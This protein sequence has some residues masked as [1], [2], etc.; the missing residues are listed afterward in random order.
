MGY[1]Q[2]RSPPRRMASDGGEKTFDPVLFDVTRIPAD[3]IA[4]Q[5]TKNDFQVFRNIQPDELTCV[6]WTG[7]HKIEKSPN[8]VEMT[9]RFNRTSFWAISVILQTQNLKLR[10]EVLSQFIRIAKRLHD[11]SNFHGMLA[12]VSALRHVSIDRLTDTWA[13]VSRTE[14]KHFDYMQ[15]FVPEGDGHQILRERFEAIQLPCIPHLGLFLKELT[16]IDIANPVQNGVEPEGRVM[17]MNNIL[18]LISEFQ[19]SDYTDLPTLPYIQSYLKSFDYINELQRFLE[20]DNYKQSYELQP[21]LVQKTKKFGTMEDLNQAPKNS[22]AA[23][24]SRGHRRTVSLGRS[25]RREL[26]TPTTNLL[27]D[28]PLSQASSPVN[29]SLPGNAISSLRFP[30][31]FRTEGSLGSNGS[32]NVSM[33]SDG[34]SVPDDIPQESI[35]HEGCLMR[36][37]NAKRGQKMAIKYWKR[38]WIV[39]T[40]ASGNGYND[41]VMLLYESRSPFIFSRIVDRRHFH[42]DSSKQ[43]VLS[44][45]VFSEECPNADELSLTDE[46]SGE[47]Y[48]FKASGAVNA[49]MWKSAIAEAKR[50]K[51]P[52]LIDLSEEMN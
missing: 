11:L 16:Y 24:F 4:M 18:R 5:I 34:L 45:F 35:I 1:F 46:T 13:R 51:I 29:G 9:Q 15:R 49:Q 21:K 50:P 44:H 40:N 39:L 52:D 38:Y 7:R 10:T 37:K 3:D 19:Q 30:K 23:R 17:K 22:I 31:T 27:D 25:P 32:S 47:C 12:I 43:M 36:K 26:E 48:R 20:D 28:R 8:V 2:C 14:K 42:R 6:G 33:R 41:N